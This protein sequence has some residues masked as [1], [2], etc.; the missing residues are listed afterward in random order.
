VKEAAEALDSEYFEKDRMGGFWNFM[1]N[2]Q[3]NLEN[4][5]AAAG[6]A[7][8]GDLEDAAQIGKNKKSS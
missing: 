3:K 6:M 1:K 7:S 8:G 4:S 2:L 5:M